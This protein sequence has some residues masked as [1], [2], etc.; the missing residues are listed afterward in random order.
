MKWRVFILSPLLVIITTIVASAQGW[1]DIVPLR[2]NCEDVKRVLKVD[3]CI[4]PESEYDL[5]DFKVIVY[6]SQNQSCD[7]D[8]RDW[9]VPPGTVT[10][11]IIS[12][13]KKMRSAELGINLSKYKKLTDTDIVGMERYESREEGV[14]VELFKGFVQNIFFYPTSK[15]ERLRCKS[16][17][18][19]STKKSHS[20]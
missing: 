12:P 18:Q 1:R 13:T 3:R 19:C 7:A 10:S 16:M 9:R 17:K 15:D 6:F 11:I 5:P 20:M 2:S 8:P 14:T 4:F